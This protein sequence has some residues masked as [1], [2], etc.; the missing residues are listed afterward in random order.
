M[1]AIQRTFL[2][3]ALKVM[4]TLLSMQAEG[5]ERGLSHDNRAEGSCGANTVAS[6]DAEL[7]DVQQES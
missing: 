1:F 6:E 4:V 3:P 7:G 2:S 5:W